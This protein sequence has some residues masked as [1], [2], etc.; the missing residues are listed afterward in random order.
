MR[1]MNYGTLMR[2]YT[3]CLLQRIGTE[4]GPDVHI[5]YKVKKVSYRTWDRERPYFFSFSVFHRGEF[6]CFY[7]LFLLLTFLSPPATLVGIFNRSGLGPSLFLRKTRRR[8]KG[9]ERRGKWGK[10]GIVGLWNIFRWVPHTLKSSE[11]NSPWLSLGSRT[12]VWK[13]RA[14]FYLSIVLKMSFPKST[15]YSYHKNEQNVQIS[16]KYSLKP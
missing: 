4:W 11:R 8:E 1:G 12:G 7:I 13:M 3:S 16:W 10:K 2:W 5:G 6:H 15:H 14:V 9:E